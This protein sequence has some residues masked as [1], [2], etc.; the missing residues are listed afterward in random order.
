MLYPTDANVF[1]GTFTP[2]YIKY[3]KAIEQEDMLNFVSP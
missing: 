3:E 1:S 2:D